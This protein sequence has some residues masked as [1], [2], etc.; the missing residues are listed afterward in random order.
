MKTLP[1]ASRH[2]LL[3][4]AVCLNQAVSYKMLHRPV[5][6]GDNFA[7]EYPVFICDW[8]SITQHLRSDLIRHMGATMIGNQQ[9]RFA[10]FETAKVREGSSESAACMEI[11]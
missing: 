6:F 1:Q 2:R 8:G 3:E 11:R 10:P 7:V 4:S 5:L 9:Y